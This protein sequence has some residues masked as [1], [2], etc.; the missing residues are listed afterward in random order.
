MT[1]SIAQSRNTGASDAQGTYTHARRDSDQYAHS[2]NSY[3]RGRCEG[4]PELE[5]IEIDHG[6]IEAD[7]SNQ[8]SLDSEIETLG[9]PAHKSQST[10]SHGNFVTSAQPAARRRVTG[11]DDSG[12][13]A[14]RRGTCPEDAQIE[15]MAWNFFN[16]VTKFSDSREDILPQE[17][18]DEQRM[19]VFAAFTDLVPE[20]VQQFVRA[21]EL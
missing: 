5:I 14:R 2:T 11:A 13:T 18:S 8:D 16:A 9:G 3:N 21:C 15:M 20:T 17:D 19:S 7:E 10:S 6:I 4:S 12:S 1:R